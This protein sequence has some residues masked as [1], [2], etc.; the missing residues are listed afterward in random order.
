VIDLGRLVGWA[1]VRFPSRLL[2]EGGA[3]KHEGRRDLL[4]S[5][6]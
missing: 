6:R 4:T 1:A 2:E 5:D 3:G